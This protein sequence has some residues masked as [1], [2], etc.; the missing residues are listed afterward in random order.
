M[1]SLGP[2]TGNGG[3]PCAVDVSGVT[4]KNVRMIDKRGNIL[5]LAVIL[6]STQNSDNSLLFIP[7]NEESNPK[8]ISD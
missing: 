6:S 3:S 5:G 8:I 7:D 2:S 1:V 4:T